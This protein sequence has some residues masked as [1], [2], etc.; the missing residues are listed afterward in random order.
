[1]RIFLSVFL[2]TLFSQASSANDSSEYYKAKDGKV[3]EATFTG[4][5]AYNYVCV[6]CHGVG[7]VGTETAPDLTE[8]AD[9]LSPEQFRL[10]VLHKK[11]IK[12]TGDDWR[13]MEQSMFEEIA[14][15]EKRDQGELANMPRWEY[16]PAI[17]DNVQNIYRY[18]KARADGVIGPD[19]P[20][21]WDSL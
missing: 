12:F 1:M 21:S 20:G 5:N 6:T 17:K 11:A 3:D 2:F 19:K 7:A 15:Q 13:N 8:I 14:K 10:R 9:R 18:L 4:W 16:N